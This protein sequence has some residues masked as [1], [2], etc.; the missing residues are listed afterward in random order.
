VWPQPDPCSWVWL[1]WCFS[2][3]VAIDFYSLVSCLRE[4]GRQISFFFLRCALTH[5]TARTYR[6]S[7]GDV[8]DLLTSKRSF[9]ASDERSRFTECDKCGQSGQ[10]RVE[11]MVQ[12]YGIDAKLFEWSHG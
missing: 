8:P 9:G 11:R 6:H 5:F 4:S 1:L 7:I 12:R 10:Y 2:L 3:Q